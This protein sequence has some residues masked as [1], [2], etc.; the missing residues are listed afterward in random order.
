VKDV[1]EL[2]QLKNAFAQPAL[3]KAT[4]YAKSIYDITSATQ[5]EIGKLVEEQVSEFNKHVVTGLDKMVKSAPAGSE[6]AVA[7]VK[8]TIS[9]VN[10][11]YDNLS[12]SAKQFAEMTAANVEA[13]TTPAS[14]VAK[15][16]AA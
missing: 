12:K 5:A 11:A 4:S 7:A 8:S 15:K 6:V 16:K 10:S 14:H 1:Q 9:A 13:A 3:E 2:A